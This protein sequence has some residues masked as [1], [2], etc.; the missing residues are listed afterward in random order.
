MSTA[1]YPALDYVALTVRLSV[2]QGPCTACDGAGHNVEWQLHGVLL[3]GE[4]QHDGACIC[5]VCFAKDPKAAV[6][7]A[8]SCYEELTVQTARQCAESHEVEA[9]V[10]GDR[11]YYAGLRRLVEAGKL[12]LPP[13]I[14]IRYV[15]GSES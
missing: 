9:Q 5:P 12:D 15:A 6:L 3:N 4:T 13:A 14:P 10:A 1:T 11:V 7:A 2:A 8:L